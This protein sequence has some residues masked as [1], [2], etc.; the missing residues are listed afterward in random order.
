MLIGEGIEPA[1]AHLDHALAS[2]DGAVAVGCNNDSNPT[3]TTLT[4]P[5]LVRAIGGAL[6]IIGT[7]LARSDLLPL[8]ELARLFDLYATVSARDDPVAGSVVERWSGMIA[9]VAVTL[10]MPNAD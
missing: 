7:I 5:V 1:A 6:A 8:D 9:D 3:A 2:L 10:D 4:D